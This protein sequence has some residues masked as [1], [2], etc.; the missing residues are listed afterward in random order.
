MTIY[1][2]FN[3]AQLYHFL[4]IFIKQSS[5]FF[6]LSQVMVNNASWKAHRKKS[7]NTASFFRRK[8]GKF[9]N[10]GIFVGFWTVYG[11]AIKNRPLK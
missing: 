9:R 5:L 8:M 6:T 4:L 1:R 7:S 2:E 11:L 10:D 3:L